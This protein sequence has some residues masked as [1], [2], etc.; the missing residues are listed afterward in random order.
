MMASLDVAVT[1]GR[2]IGNELT[3]YSEH[4]LFAKWFPEISDINQHHPFCNN[5]NAAVRKSV[6]KEY[7]YD[8]TLTGL[9]DLDFAKRVQRDGHQISYVADASIVHVHEETPSRIYN[10]YRREAFALS[11]IMEA[12]KM[13]LLDLCRLWS[14]NTFSDLY[15]A[16]L[17]GQLV[18]NLWDI[19][20]FRA[21]Q[22]LGAYRGFRQRGSVDATLRRRFYYPNSLDRPMKDSLT[23]QRPVDYAHVTSKTSS[24]S[25]QP[26]TLIKS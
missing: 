18:R 6:W 8:E 14:G 26:A 4:R 2:Q 23:R 3:K 16:C 10:R 9:E 24:E 25:S 5:A 19:P 1:Y 17:D 22:F 21:M 11:H 13:S 15:H 7:K 12:E 20:M